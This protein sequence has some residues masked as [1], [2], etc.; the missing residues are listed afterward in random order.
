MPAPV[1]N[2]GV[3]DVAIAA[4]LYNKFKVYLG[5]NT[6]ANTI[7]RYPME[8]AQREYAEKE[9]NQVIDF[10]S[11]YRN[12]TQFSWER[13]RSSVA[14]AG[15]PLTYTDSSMTT[16]TIGRAIPLDLT[17]EIVFWHLDKDVINVLIENFFFWLFSY[18]TLTIELQNFPT[19]VYVNMTENPAE[20]LSTI[21]NMYQVGKYWVFKGTMK[22]E[23]WI[24]QIDES[25][26]TIYQ[27][28]CKIWYKEAGLTSNLLLGT[29]TVP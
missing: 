18:P 17:Y 13:N 21:R 24:P 5:N 20:D 2:L 6:Q 28:I 4:A 29:V 19:S 12:V 1:S 7:I 16:Q 22:F 27:I 26:S 11:F 25:N 10:I 23:S 15:V 3:I 8:V 9:G 14:L